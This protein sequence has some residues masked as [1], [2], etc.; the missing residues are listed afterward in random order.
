MSSIDERVVQMQFQNSQFEK[1]VKESIL[2]LEKLKESLKLEEAAAG[3]KK[4]QE[5]GDSFSLV[6][7][8]EDVD[9]LSE[10]FSAFGTFA[11]RIVENLADTIYNKL[12]AA[13]ND[14]TI[15][16]IGSG[17]QRYAE[18]TKAVQTIMFATGE[19]IEKVEEELERLTWFTDETSYSY[20]D[21]VSNISKFT[22]AGVGLEDAR[23]SMQGIATWAASAGQDAAT[24]SRVMYNASQALGAGAMKVTDWRSIE[25]ANM[26]TKEF[27]QNVIETAIALGKLDQQGNLLVGSGKNAKLIQVTSDSFRE[28]LR[29]GWF[30]T[31]IMTSI[32]SQYGE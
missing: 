10:R 30:D 19:S 16:Q 6:K 22:S 14:V 17:W 3:L 24:A 1:G 15:G 27:K 8:S 5:A 9:G 28:T 18:D 7:I 31:D 11:G 4:L 12:G 20:T 13:L 26:A 23:V 25:L 32:F 29:Y 2:S 21:M